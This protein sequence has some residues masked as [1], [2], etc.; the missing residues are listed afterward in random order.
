MNDK[1]IYPSQLLVAGRV[2]LDVA[3]DNKKRIFE[4]VGLAFENTDGP[5]RGLVFKHLLER[6]RLGSTVISDGVAVPH[7]R[8][9]NLRQPLAAYLRVLN[10]F[11]FDSPD[12]PI[13]HMFILLVPQRADDTH[14]KIL[15]VMSRMLIDKEFIAAAEAC[16]DRAA[17]MNLMRDWETKHIVTDSTQLAA[18]SG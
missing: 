4:E 2:L 14:L 10:P 7:A 16:T 17:F 13:R 6:E 18:T 1:I 12:N 9:T 15:S 8:I 3:S 11:I 5:A